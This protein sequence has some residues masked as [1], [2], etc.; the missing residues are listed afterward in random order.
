MENNGENQT[1]SFTYSAKQQEE[2]RRIRQKYQPAQPDKMEQ[3]RRLDESATR[4]GMIVGL[5]MGT[6][7]TLVLGLG[8]SCAMVWA[9]ELFLPG[10]V[11]GLAGIAMVALAYPL[12]LAITRRQRKKIA[13]E[14]LRLSDE[15]MQ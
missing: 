15:L 1:F 13:P 8:M 4:P 5:S 6:V 12:Y 7:G 9:G 10:I 11:I 14:I 2:V 3:L